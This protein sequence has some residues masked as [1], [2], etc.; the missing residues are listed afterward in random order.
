M[1]PWGV[2]HWEKFMGEPAE[3]GEVTYDA[4]RRWSRKNPC[5]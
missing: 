5:K 3:I 2:D 1:M 4:V